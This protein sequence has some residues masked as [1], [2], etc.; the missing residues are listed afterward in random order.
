MAF[1]IVSTVQ[2][3]THSIYDSKG[4]TSTRYKATVYSAS[5]N[6]AYKLFTAGYI[7]TDMVTSTF[8]YTVYLTFYFH[9]GFQYN[10]STCVRHALSLCL[11]FTATK[12]PNSQ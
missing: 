7:R 4:F 3:D 2:G 12:T 9:C 10:C 6:M 11:F 8:T 1:T 5:L